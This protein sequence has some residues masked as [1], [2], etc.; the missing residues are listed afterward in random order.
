L[1]ICKTIADLLQLEEQFQLA[2]DL[3]WDCKIQLKKFQDEDMADV[4]QETV[5]PGDVI[6]A[7]N[8]AGRGADFKTSAELE[9]K[10]GLHVCVGFCPDNER[11]RDQAYF[12]TSR[13]GN[14]GSAQLLV[15]ESEIRK[16]NIDTTNLEEIDFDEVSETFFNGK[17][18][19]LI[20]LEN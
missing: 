2:K 5:V 3:T 19:L 16:L 11:V 9:E 13:Q 18:N 1:I 8:I 14:K 4:T 10:G 15:R 6:L 12:R 17:W 7:T 20:G